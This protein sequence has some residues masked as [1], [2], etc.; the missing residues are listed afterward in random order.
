VEEQALH[1]IVAS[2]GTDIEDNGCWYATP[3]AHIIQFL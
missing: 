1:D 2:S 3:R